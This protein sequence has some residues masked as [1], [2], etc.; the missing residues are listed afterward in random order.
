M[1]ATRAA[2]IGLGC[3]KCLAMRTR[4]TLP[5]PPRGATTP[6]KSRMRSRSTPRGRAALRGPWRPA[7][8]KTGRKWQLP[9]ARRQD[10]APEVAQFEAVLQEDARGRDSCRPLWNHEA[11]DDRRL[12]ASRWIAVRGPWCEVRSFM[13]HFSDSTFAGAQAECPYFG[14]APG[15]AAMV[16]VAAPE[17]ECE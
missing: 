1:T 5:P 10:E 14:R 7:A 2:P 3:A 15:E 13:L 17:G 12:W 6:A 11:R 8:E 16:P 9:A 4:S